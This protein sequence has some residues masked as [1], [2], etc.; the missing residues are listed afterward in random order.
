MSRSS[1]FPRCLP[2][3]IGFGNLGVRPEGRGFLISGSATGA[4]RVLNLDQYCLVESYSMEENRVRYR[5]SIKA[6]SESM[7]HG[8][9]YSA[10]PEVN[11]VIH[12]HGRSMFDSLLAR[13]QI[14]TP[15]ELPYG[16]PAMAAIALSP[17]HP[18]TRRWPIPSTPPARDPD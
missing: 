16:T 5:G 4:D 18:S 13:G 15:A 17:S 9:I 6:S 2:N 7:S 12:I 14:H 3:G 1:Q 11:C 10:D 8:A